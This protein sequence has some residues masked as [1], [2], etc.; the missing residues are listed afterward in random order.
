MENRQ[1]YPLVTLLIVTRNEKEYIE[2]SLLSLINQTYPKELIEIIIVDGMSTDGTREFLYKKVIELRQKGINIKL[3]DNP[4][5]ILAS[6]WNIGIKNAKGDIV[7]RIDTHSEI[8]PNYVEIGVN[9]LLK[10]RKEQVVCVGGVLKSKGKGVM[11]KAI[12]DLFSSKFGMGNSAFRVGVK[13][14]KFTD[15]AVFG[16]YWKWIFDEV[17]YFNESLER[18]Q[19]IDLHYKILKRGYKFLTHPEMKAI[20]YVRNNISSMIKKAFGDGYWAIASG[21]A[22]FRHKVPLYFVLYVISFFIVSMVSYFLKLYNLLLLFSLPL[23]MYIFLLLFFSLKDGKGYS[24]F[25][26]LFLFPAFHVSYG[27]GSLIAYLDKFIKKLRRFIL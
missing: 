3:L 14:P 20:Y 2:K 10:R 18:N 11:G 23:M 1:N 21:K 22:Y 24:K 15:T 19:D 8:S 9:E 17:D 12:A 26:L 27:L 4:N 13:E 5:K 25:L 7:C 6:G 16:L